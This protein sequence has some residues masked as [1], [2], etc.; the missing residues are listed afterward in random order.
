MD[1]KVGVIVLSVL[2]FIGLFLVAGSYTG[3]Q[4]YGGSW[5]NFQSAEPVYYNYGGNDFLDFYYSYA[6]W[7]DFVLF[8]LLF[9]MLGKLILG[10]HFEYSEAKPLY[11]VL[12][13]ILALSL[14]IWEARNGIFVIDFLGQYA[15]IFIILLLVFLGV[16]GI[17]KLPRAGLFTISLVYLIIYYVFILDVAGMGGGFIFYELLYYNYFLDRL[18]FFLNIL[19]WFGAIIGLFLM[20]KGGD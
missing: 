5:A 14:S 17:K 7:I 3:F 19:A 12:G 15:F 2:T 8:T 10:Q 9:L 18:L 20:F 1:K 4:F 16:W 6:S 11:V 13:I